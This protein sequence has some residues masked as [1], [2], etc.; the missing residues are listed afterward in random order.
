MVS[1]GGSLLYELV[2]GRR[3]RM[4]YGQEL[5]GAS[6]CAASDP[7]AGGAG[8]KELWR[9]HPNPA[10]GGTP[11]AASGARPTFLDGHGAAAF[12]Q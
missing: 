6:S 11:S 5:G 9:T 10:R 4:G 3:L 7:A 8:A 12:S 1:P 2:R